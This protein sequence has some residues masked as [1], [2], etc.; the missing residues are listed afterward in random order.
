MRRTRAGGLV[1]QQAAM[2]ACL[3]DFRLMVLVTR[4]GADRASAA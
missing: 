2:I 1:Q 3:D 4:L